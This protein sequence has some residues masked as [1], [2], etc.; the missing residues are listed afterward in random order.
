MIYKNK[1][2]DENRNN[3]SSHHPPVEDEDEDVIITADKEEDPGETG[4]TTQA[5][6]KQTPE[7]IKTLPASTE[8]GEEQ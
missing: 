1:M 3:I 2:S 6:D 8:N 7:D 4:Q 5:S